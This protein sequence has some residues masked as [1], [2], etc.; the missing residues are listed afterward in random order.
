MKKIMILLFLLSCNMFFSQKN[1]LFLVK[2]K[3]LNDEGAYFQFRH[4]SYLHCLDRHLGHKNE[5]FMSEWSDLFNRMYA[6]PRLFNEDRLIT[7]L[8]ENESQH[9]N[10][11]KHF[12]RGCFNVKSKELFEKF[13]LN[14]I[15]YIQPS[16]YNPQE[17][18]DQDRADY[19]NDGKININRFVP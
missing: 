5:L 14:D 16:P 3:L 19:L 1:D 4:L 12:Y 10:K 6:F 15:N 18:I 17:D 9:L 13:I 7:F 2:N 11:N 8:N